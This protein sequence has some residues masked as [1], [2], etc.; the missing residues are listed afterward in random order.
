MKRIGILR[1]GK[2]E[3]QGTGSQDRE[4]RLVEKGREAVRA[5]AANSACNESH[6]DMVVTSPAV[7]AVESAEIFSREAGISTPVEIREELY[8]AGPRDILSLVNGLPDEVGSILIVGHNPSLEEFCEEITGEYTGLKTANL[9]ILD[10]DADSWTEIYPP[11]LIIQQR[12]IK[13]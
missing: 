1:H 3:H 11:S 5:V 2:A 13:P 4:R 12:L 9:L 8:A 10:I 6:P 7:R